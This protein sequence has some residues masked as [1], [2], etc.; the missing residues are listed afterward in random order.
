MLL[1]NY[2][3]NLLTLDFMG[4]LTFLQNLPTDTWSEREVESILAQAYILS[5]LFDQ[6]PSHLN[7][8]Y[9]SGGES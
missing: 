6:S 4:M 5:H 1:M 3:T 7:N 2:K 8:T 9:T